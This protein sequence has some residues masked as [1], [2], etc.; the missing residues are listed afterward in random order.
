MEEKPYVPGSLILFFF[1]ERMATST[2]GQTAQMQERLQ[3]GEPKFNLYG[4]KKLLA[5]NNEP[6]GKYDKL[7]KIAT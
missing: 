1:C 5:K 6:F 3:R 7:K 4:L 2:E